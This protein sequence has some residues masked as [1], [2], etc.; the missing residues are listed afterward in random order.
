MLLETSPVGV[1]VW[2]AA[3]GA[4]APERLPE[5]D[6]YALVNAA[7]LVV[8]DDLTTAFV[9][10]DRPADW[11]PFRLHFIDSGLRDG[12]YSY[13][14]SGV[15]IFGRHSAIS[16]PARWHQWTPPPVPAP[17]YFETPHGNRP[18]GA[19]LE[20]AVAVLDKLGPPPP[21][22]EAWALDP[23]DPTVLRDA[24]YLSWRATLPEDQ[25]DAVVGLRV[26]WTWSDV[27]M[28]AAPDT[29][30]FRIYL[31][32]NR[33]NTFSGRVVS[34]VASSPGRTLVETNL[35]REVDRDA[36]RGAVLRAGGKSFEVVG[37]PVGPSLSLEVAN[38]GPDRDVAPE[39][40]QRFGLSIATLPSHSEH[41][42]P[43]V[44]ASWDTRRH[45][46]DIGDY[47]EE[48]VEER[49]SGGAVVQIRVRIYD[50]F[51]PQ[52]DEAPLRSLPI[53]PSLSQTVVYAEVG[54]SAADD[55]T[56]T[57]DHQK[58][59]TTPWGGRPGNEGRVGGPVSVFRVFRGPLPSPSPTFDDE[60]LWAT[61]ADYYGASYFEFALEP[62]DYLRTHVLRAL[63]EALFKADWS[64]RPRPPLSAIDEVFPDP[65]Q[66]PRWTAEKRAAVAL[67]LNAL[68]AFGSAPGVPDEALTLYRRGLSNDALRIL[69]GLPGVKAAYSQRTI[70]SLPSDAA[71]Y[72]DR[73]DGRANNRY[74]YRGR[75]VDEAH[76][77]GPLGLA[78]PPV[79]L[80]KVTPPPAP[81][82]VRIVAGSEDP[83]DPGD[84][85]VV[86]Q[87]R[88]S[89]ATDVLKYLVFRTDT[90]EHQR[91]TRLM[92]QVAQVS[93]PGSTQ[94]RAA[95]A[96]VD[97]E[98]PPGVTHYY[99]VVAVDEAG[100]W[101]P[102]SQPR[103]VRSFDRR[104]PA[105]PEWDEPALEGDGLV[106]T[107]RSDN[108]ALR[109]LVQ[110]RPRGDEAW[111]TVGRWLPRG[112]YEVVDLTREHDVVYEYRLR[113]LDSA[114]R[115]NSAYRV[116]EH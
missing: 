21:P 57:T 46:V 109:S 82:I 48:R 111:V 36:F 30:E 68:N 81:Q 60:A 2:R 32:A 15:D 67:E 106:L 84:G 104:G 24:R 113:V 105:P 103:A 35:V 102:A 93:A 66:E 70:E 63:D 42:D 7:P 20:G 1:H 56:H 34:T 29:R 110:R 11:P 45:V 52:G 96:F 16:V 54:V 90:R 62:R 64:R 33:F 83:D 53:E 14:V 75:Y 114:G 59:S 101:S 43:S 44:A 89:A 79:Y 71:P 80:P 31:R 112:S 55:K 12:S 99:R 72:R 94:P 97:S 98:V 73:L 58:W 3:L 17:W 5:S 69:A 47:V 40:M 22:L 78:S 19:Y 87:W 10:R 23:A 88:P 41:L 6:E 74:F 115:Q 28:A 116:L 27:E 18:I 26:R 39:P 86:V 38:M 65:V 49:T 50:L 85:N 77:R 107:W 8:G 91:D 76:N 25:R 37:N 100:N 108:T 9:S 51:L 4:E 92:T 13:G 95:L 61:P